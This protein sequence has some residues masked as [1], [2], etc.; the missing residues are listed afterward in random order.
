[1]ANIWRN[2]VFDRTLSD[3]NS[4][5]R[6]IENWK[7]SHNHIVNITVEHDRISIN[8]GEITTTEDSVIFNAD[9]VAYVENDAL[10]V[11]LGGVYDLKGCLNV[12]DLNRIEDNISYIANR[13]ISYKYP[14]V[15][16]SKEWVKTDLPNANDMKRIANNIKSICNGFAPL[17]EEVTIPETLL[18]YQD[19]NNLEYCLHLLSKMLEAMIASFVQSGTYKCGSTNRLPRRR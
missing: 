8:E 13:L 5:I 18:S 17:S 16:A 15:V 19:I 6:Q 10:V 11:R 12:S 9:G 2:P 1:M 3:V 7:K 4:A 14:I